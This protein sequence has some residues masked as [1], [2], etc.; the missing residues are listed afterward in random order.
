MGADTI[1][2]SNYYGNN[3]L[4]LNGTSIDLN[5]ASDAQ[6]SGVQIIDASSAVSPTL[7]DLS[8]QTEVFTILASSTVAT[9][10]IGSAGDDAFTVFT[11][12]ETIDGGAGSNTLTVNATN[13]DLN[14]A[15]D[16]QFK[17]V[18][19]I[20]LTNYS[21]NLDLSKQSE[22]FNINASGNYYNYNNGYYNADTITGSQGADSITLN[23]NDTVIGFVGA[24]TISGG[25]YYG[26][27]TLILNGTSIDLN[28]ASDAQLSGVQIIDA[29]SAV[30]PTL[31][32]LSK[33]T[34][35]FTILASS[36]VA[37]SIIG[38]AG[39]D[40]FTVFTSTETIDGG[41]GSNTLTVN[42]TNTDLNNA[43]DEQFKN[44]QNI[45]LNGGQNINLDLSKQSEG[46]KIT[47]GYYAD[48]ITGSQGADSI[49]LR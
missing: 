13:T 12:T 22:G 17:N 30:S 15:S 23:S 19:N 39:D 10:I 31:I 25:N 3:T 4:I 5:N 49:T 42:A 20:A 44:V 38:S 2:G 7:I 47:S 14:N 36:T 11:S 33:Q 8:K 16:E 28:N 46:F 40:A 9:S 43:S 48:T 29:S 24:D 18:Q 35:V 45:V 34:E 26:N 6:L 21:I 32:D 41:A 1:S 27:N 37:T